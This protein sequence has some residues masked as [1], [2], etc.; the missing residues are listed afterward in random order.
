MSQ[1]ALFVGWGAIIAGREK[2]AARVLGEARQY[3]QGLQS[4]GLIDSAEL[5]LLE[6]HGGDLEGFVLIKGEREAIARLRIDPEFTAVIVGVQLV[7]QKVGVVG[8]HTGAALGALLQT[9]DQQEA[10]LL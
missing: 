6:P 2:S 3:L 5:V 1:G 7:H 9:W 4:R 10:R 8:A